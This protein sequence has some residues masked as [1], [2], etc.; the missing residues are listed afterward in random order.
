MANVMMQLKASRICGESKCVIVQTSS[1]AS[2]NTSHDKPSIT[3]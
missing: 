3:M 1:G 2:C